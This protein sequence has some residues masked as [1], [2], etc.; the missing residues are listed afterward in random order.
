MT[1]AAAFLFSVDKFQ[2]NGLIRGERIGHAAS[3]NSRQLF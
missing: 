2:G 1:D 3:P